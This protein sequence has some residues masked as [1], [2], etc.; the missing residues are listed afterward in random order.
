M[1]YIEEIQY[2]SVLEWSYDKEY[3]YITY[4]SMRLNVNK[5]CMRFL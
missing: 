5:W 3:L 1:P 4:D 2:H